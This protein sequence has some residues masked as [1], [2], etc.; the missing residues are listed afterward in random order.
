MMAGKPSIFGLSVRKKT[1]ESEPPQRRF[2]REGRSEFFVEMGENEDWN[3]PQY[4]N[5]VRRSELTY[6]KELRGKA[7]GGLFSSSLLQL[8]RDSCGK[9]DPCT[10]EI[11]HFVN[12]V[13]QNSAGGGGVIILSWSCRH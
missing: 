13:T 7:P 9:L 2:P 10:E 11:A 6:P 1:E 5:G 12:L 4:I 8:V 3:Q